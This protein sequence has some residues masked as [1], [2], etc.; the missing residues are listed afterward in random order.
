M[1]V[2]ITLIEARAAA[3]VLEWKA[4]EYRHA[5]QYL[6]PESGPA[7]LEIRE[8]TLADAERVKKVEDALMAGIDI[9]IVKE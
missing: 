3:R 9:T 8:Q 4:A 5:A 2:R 6:P 1:P 7:Y